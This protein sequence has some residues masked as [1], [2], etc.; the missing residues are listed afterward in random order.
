ML[1]S[2]D[3]VCPMKPWSCDECAAEETQKLID[4]LNIA[5]TNTEE[6]RVQAIQAYNSGRVFFS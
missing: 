1:V 3:Y 6:F 4:N 5:I 2:Q